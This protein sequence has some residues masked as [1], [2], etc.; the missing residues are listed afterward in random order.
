MSIAAADGL[1]GLDLALRGGSSAT[2]V[3]QA[4]CRARGLD[5]RMRIRRLDAAGEATP[6]EP[7]GLLHALRPRYRRIRMYC[8]EVAVSEAENWYDAAALSEAMNHV[9]DHSDTPFGLAVA[10]LGFER[11]TLSSRRGEAGLEHRA[12]LFAPGRATP[13]CVVVEHYTN[14]P[15]GGPAR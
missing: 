1:S 11:R 2:V 6:R 14:G 7:S 9:L 4:W 10:E 13:F 3:L 12:A 8:G 5:G 15:D